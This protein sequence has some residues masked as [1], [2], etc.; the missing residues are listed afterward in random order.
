MVDSTMPDGG[1]EERPELLEDVEEG[2][3]IF[4]GIEGLDRAVVARVLDV[5]EDD[6]ENQRIIE[7]LA[8]VQEDSDPYQEH[9]NVILWSSTESE[10][11][12][13]VD[14]HREWLTEDGELADEEAEYVG[15]LEVL[16][17]LEPGGEPDEPDGWTSSADVQED[18]DVSQST[19]AVLSELFDS[20]EEVQDH[21]EH[22]NEFLGFR[23][24]SVSAN[25]EIS[26]ALDALEDDEEED[27]VQDDV[28]DGR[29]VE[30][31]EVAELLERGLTPPTAI[32]YLATVEGPYT[33]A[34][35]SE[36]RGVSQQ[37]ISDNVRKAHDELAE[38]K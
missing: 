32:D 22:M 24:I 30:L 38:D 28:E 1:R 37:A 13:G 31:E 18:L 5:L 3:K 36:I 34:E 4:L 20:L 2:A 10:T 27:D 23:G 8:R 12:P 16:D 21:Y 11:W 17:V 9:E 35:W 33:Q 19:A 15:A 7:V 26:E 25:E 6:D 29:D 14:A